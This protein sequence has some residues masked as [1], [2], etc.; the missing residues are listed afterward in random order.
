[1]NI[2]RRRYFR[3]NELVGIAYEV[4]K[5]NIIDENE[6]TAYTPD[7]L[8]LATA[9]D[10]KIDKLLKEVS[11][12]DP[13]I[14]ELL[15][16]INQ[17]L[18]RVTNYLNV[19]APLVKRIANKVQEANLSACGMAFNNHELFI[20]GTRLQLELTL[21]PSEEKITTEGIVIGCDKL[22][23]TESYY[24]RIDFLG[25]EERTQEKLIQYIVQSQ[26][27]QLKTDRSYS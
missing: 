19:E 27:A 17:K 4:I 10:L 15:S 12:S 6:K 11:V 9:Q 1:M 22:E 25:M 26:S 16:L 23:D 8:E 24:C 2:E 7:L 3:I 13:K 18:E 21:Y 20:C 5:S 14:A